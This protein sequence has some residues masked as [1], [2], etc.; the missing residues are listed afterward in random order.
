MFVVFAVVVQPVSEILFKSGFTSMA[1]MAV[2]AVV[3]CM[4]V[5]VLLQP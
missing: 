2:I 4:L 5:F 1:T 3:L